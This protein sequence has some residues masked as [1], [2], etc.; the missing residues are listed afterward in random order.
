MT[1]SSCNEMWDTETGTEQT[2]KAKK[3]TSLWSWTNGF[4]MGLQIGPTD[5]HQIAGIV[6]VEI[7]IHL[8]WS[9]L[10]FCKDFIMPLESIAL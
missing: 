10:H 2:S 5:L 1:A 4:K 7:H 3:R 9:I 6:I 8:N